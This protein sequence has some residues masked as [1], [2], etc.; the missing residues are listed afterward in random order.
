MY[1]SFVFLLRLTLYSY[2]FYSLYV[3]WL[4]N[5]LMTTMMIMIIKMLLVLLLLLMIMMM[6]LV[7]MQVAVS[8]AVQTVA[9][10]FLTGDVTGTMTVL[11]TAMKWIAV[12]CIFFFQTCLIFYRIRSQLLV[13]FLA[14]VNSSSCSLYVIGRPSVCRLSSVC[15]VRAPYSGDWNFRQYFYAIWYAGHLLTF[16]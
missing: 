1:A 8:S 14:D 3:K 2:M 4:S 15:N 5:M 6:M 16:R 13:P 7:L 9:V 12:S 11:T 10:C